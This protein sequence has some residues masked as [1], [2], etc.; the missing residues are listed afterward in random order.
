M[1]D[2]NE[3]PVLNFSPEVRIEM[4]TVCGFFPPLGAIDLGEE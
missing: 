4:I 2:L 1:T 3:S